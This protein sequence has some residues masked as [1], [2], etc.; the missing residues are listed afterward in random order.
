MNNLP[1]TAIEEPRPY[2]CEFCSKS[3]YRLEHKVRHVRTHTGEK[4]HGCI[5]EN[6]SKRFSRSDELRRHIRTHNLPSAM[7]IRRKRKA[8]KEQLPQDLEDY[9][10]QQQRCSILRLDSDIIRIDNS[11]ETTTTKEHIPEQQRHTR[12]H[13]VRS[14]SV[15]HHCLASNCFKSFWRKG[16]LIR[17]IDKHHGIQVTHI[18]V[19]DKEKMIKLLQSASLIPLT[20]RPSDASTCSS[21]TTS[22]NSLTESCTSPINCSPQPVIVEPDA[23][24]I[25]SI[26][27]AY[28]VNEQKNNGVSLPS[29]KDMFIPP[30]SESS[31]N[32]ISCT[33]PSFKTLFSN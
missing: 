33:L 13:R 19:T 27:P 26:E 12:Q 28:F 9:A 18:D 3:F 4:P 29:F 16:Q 24:Q 10:K 2:I 32:R 30:L 1:N 6:C 5:F 14:S 22:S 15:L 31:S 8:S 23:F 11:D 17:H 21:L 20:R 7:P 25:H